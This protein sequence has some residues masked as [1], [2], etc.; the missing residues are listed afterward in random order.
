MC[1]IVA[2]ASGSTASRLVALVERFGELGAE[3]A[4][5][6]RDPSTASDVAGLPVDSLSSLVASLLSSGDS[7]SAVATVLTGHLDSRT[8]RA[9]GELVGGRYAST[10]RFL[11]VEG[12]LSKQ[13][14]TAMVARAR[15][16]RLDFAVLSEPW[17]EGRISGDAVRE[18]TVGIRGALRR[19]GLPGSQR[20]VA[21][22]TALD[23]VL[24]VAQ[25]G[26][27]EDVRRVIGHLT[28]LADPDGATQAE[29]DAHDDQSLTMTRVGAVSTL[30][31][32]LTNENAA[33]VMTVLTQK[34]DAMRRD[35]ELTGGDLLPSATEPGTFDA[36][37][38]R[39]SR[40]AHLLAIAFSDTFVGLLDD[41]R[42][43]S[44]HGIAPHVTVT[45][46]LARFEAGLGGDLTMPGSD[47]RVLVSNQSVRRILCDSDVTTVVVRPSAAAGSDR[48]RSTVGNLLLEAAR[49]VLYVGRAERVVPPRLR[50]ALEARDGHCR[51]PGC[52]AH[53]RR[54]HAHHV[55][56]WENG[57]STAIDNCVLLC[58]R[59]HHAVHE[60][61][62]SLS[63]APGV[64]P[65]ATGHWQFAP[66]ER[67]RRPR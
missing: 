49:E 19:S 62:W 38:V 51:F 41:N 60:G 33:A 12:G 4:V 11:E 14:A 25:V 10:H 63:R 65:G 57:G 43:G 53:V 56:E 2:Q 34:V 32:V 45:V 54:C 59:H 8:G 1:S 17:L 39:S 29:M 67:P 58:V 16:L 66:P 31:A 42:V 27:V 15:D 9:T 48:C 3:I 61:G 37:R 24:P 22:K 18:V 13:R 21:R 26:T 30:T 7:A 50:R 35:G 23:A 40:Y 36:R 28:L 5:M 6:L 55:R 47:A 44:H 20:E 52:Q 64:P 46:D